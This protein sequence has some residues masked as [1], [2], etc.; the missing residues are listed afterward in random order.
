MY[1]RIETMNKNYTSFAESIEFYFKDERNLVTQKIVKLQHKLAETTP[2]KE[3]ECKESVLKMPTLSRIDSYID[4][5]KRS[6]LTQFQTTVSV[7]DS[8]IQEF[9]N[10]NSSL[11]K[12]I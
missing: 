11:E 5:D 1:Q 8:K 9:E 12:D 4:I 10:I 7:L 2:R 3:F 6:R